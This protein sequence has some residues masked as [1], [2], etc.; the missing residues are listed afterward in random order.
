[1]HIKKIFLVHF[2]LLLTFLNV[3]KVRKYKQRIFQYSPLPSSV[4]LSYKF[5]YKAQGDFAVFI[6]QTYTKL[7]NKKSLKI[8]K[9]HV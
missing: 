6:S 9:Q 8:K 5:S 4:L 1:M 2:L 3:S 7:K